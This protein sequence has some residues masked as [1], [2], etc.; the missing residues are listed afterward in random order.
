MRIYEKP[1]MFTTMNKWLISIA[2][3]TIAKTTEQVIKIIGTLY[4]Q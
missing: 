4:V 2:I 1:S 3:M